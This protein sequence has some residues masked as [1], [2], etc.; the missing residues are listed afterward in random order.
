MPK[1]GGEEAPAVEGEASPVGSLAT[2]PLSLR[3]AGLQAIREEM[4]RRV[5]KALQGEEELY[6]SSFRAGAS[7]MLALRGALE[8]VKDALA[9]GFYFGFSVG[10]TDARY[11]AGE[12]GEGEP[13]RSGVV[14]AEEVAL[15]A[16]A[17]FVGEVGTAVQRASTEGELVEAFSRLRTEWAPRFA[18]GAAVRA[19]SAGVLAGAA[20]RGLSVV[21]VLAD[22]DDC[23]GESCRANA[24]AGSVIPGASFPSGHDSP[25][26]HPGC[27]CSVV[28][29][30]AALRASG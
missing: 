5:V 17:A 4:L 3:E 11:L 13:A 22:E 2:D 28:P 12:A 7:G 10:S 9:G 8:R 18:E 29:V 30:P 15:G 14:D 20:A 23:P 21:W 27:R 16:A 25:P 26:A 19:Y 6:L 1:P 24:A